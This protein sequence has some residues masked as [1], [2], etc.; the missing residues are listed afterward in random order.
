MSK[1]KK[2]REPQDLPEKETPAAPDPS[3]QA[4]EAEEKQ[5]E[6][7]PSKKEQSSK[8]KKPEPKEPTE[9][10]Q[11][12]A[13]YDALN[14]RLMRTLAE[15]DNWRK[16]TQRE[17]DAMYNDGRANAVE[18]IVPVLD[19]FERALACETQDQT[20]YQGVEMIYHTMLDILKKLGVEPFGE[21]GET[22]DPN[23]HNAVMQAADEELQEGQVAQVFQ[24]GYQLGE[25]IIRHAMVSVVK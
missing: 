10:E 22:F 24:K 23:R 3:E 11:L 6:D 13:K 18:Q 15:Y 17:K 12:T 20:F 4:P 1:Q 5:A 9:L 25:R 19:T 2:D 8:D 7:N 21:R 14:D 16:R